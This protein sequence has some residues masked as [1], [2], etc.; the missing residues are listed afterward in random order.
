MTVFN[1]TF[2]DLKSKKDICVLWHEAE[3]G[4]C[5]ADVA[6]AYVKV[7]KLM[8]QYSSFCFWADNCCAQN[9]N[10]TLISALW[11]FVNQPHG[12][13]AIEIKFLEK[14]HTFMRP[15]SVHGAIGNKFKKSDAV[16]DWN[17]LEK[18]ISSASSH[19]PISSLTHA[20]VYRFEN[21]HLKSLKTLPKLKD[22]KAIMVKR[23]STKMHFKFHHYEANYREKEFLHLKY[24]EMD[25]IHFFPT[26]LEKARGMNKK[27][28]RR[29]YQNFGSPHD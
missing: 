27:K 4:R 21:L 13:D 8:S 20:D 6:S 19:I 26:R 25:P 11:L 2:C 24:R 28:E 18:L 1:E 9:K 23:G 17:D 3:T 14:G 22:L 29:N 16:H 10:W 12:P 15:N 5:A 7:M